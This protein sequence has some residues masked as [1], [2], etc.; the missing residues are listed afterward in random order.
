[1][2]R[3]WI[4]SLIV[5]SCTKGALSNSLLAPCK[6]E[7][8]DCVRN[9]VNAAIPKIL[10]GIPELGVETSDPLFLEKIEGNLSIL[11]YKFYNTTI[12][13]YKDCA[14]TNLK[15]SPDLS[16]VHY[17]LNCPKFKL[18]GQYDI[19]GRLII[20]PVEG[21]GDYELVT[22]K[23]KIDVDSDLK[24]HTGSDGKTY[25]SIKNFKLKCKALTPILFDFK[26]LFNG[27]K[28]LSDAVHKFANE[29]WPEVAELVQD[30]TFY[31]CMNKITRN[32]NKYLKTVPLDDFKLN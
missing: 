23:Y 30:P 4:F 13:G 7:D 18:S 20:L 11:K 28:D 29:N 25:L 24:I 1:M 22:G 31:A 3:E 5:A 6:I 14:V 27:Q 15:T 8:E 32:V 16:S 12:I 10:Q 9:S 21:N 26:N 2:F 19:S 17:V